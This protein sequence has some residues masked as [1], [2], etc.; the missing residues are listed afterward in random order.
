MKKKL[1]ALLGAVASLA[2]FAGCGEKECTHTYD[3][4]CDTTCNDCGE[5]RTPEA[6]VYDNACDTDCN[7]CGDV[8]TIEHTYDNA[9]DASCNVC[10]D[11]RTPAAHVYDNDCD[12][13]CNVCD[14]TRTASDHV[15]DNACDASC[16]VC[17]DE[18]TPADHVYDNACDASCNVCDD[19]REI[20]HDFA[21]QKGFRPAMFF[22]GGGQFAIAATVDGA[23]KA[24][25]ALGADKNYGYMPA[26]DV[27][28]A[29]GG[30]FTTGADVVYTFTQ[31]GMAD[32]TIQAPDGRYVYMTGTFNSFNLSVDEPTEGHIWTVDTSTGAAK[33]INKTTNKW[34]QYDSNY[35]TYGAYD[36]DK[37]TLPSLYNYIGAS[38]ITDE[39]HHWTV[40]SVCET[41]SDKVA[42]SGGTA[43]CTAQAVCDDCGTSYGDLGGHTFEYEYWMNTDDE[44]WIECDNCN[45][46][47]EGTVGSHSYTLIDSTHAKYDYAACVC[48]KKDESTAFVKKVD[49]LNQTLYLGEQDFIDDL[50]AAAISIAGIDEYV[51]ISSIKV[52]E[53]DLGTDPAALVYPSELKA[54]KTM[55]GKQNIVVTV[56]DAAGL[57][58][59]ILVPV[60][61]ITMYITDVE[62]FESIQPTAENPAIYGYYVLTADITDNSLAGKPY[63]TWNAEEGFF[64]TFDGNGHTIAAAANG[65]SGIFGILRNATIKN[66]TIKD[67]W[68]SNYNGA[69]LI[70]KASF[71]STFNNIEVKLVAGSGNPNVGMTG[72]MTSGWLFSAEFSGN[73]VENFHVDLGTATVGN[74]FGC[75][76]FGNTFEDVTVVGNYTQIG[77]MP[78][79][80][81]EDGNEISAEA[82]ISLEDVEAPISWVEKVEF[83]EVQVIDLSDPNS[84]IDLGDYADAV[85]VS[86]VTAEGYEFNGLSAE[87]ASAVLKNTPSAHG[88]TTI[89]VTVDVEWFGLHE[90]SIPAKIVTRTIK[91]MQEL[92]TYTKSPNNA[93]AV[94]DGYYMLANDVAYN[95]VY[96]ANGNVVS[97]GTEGAVAYA[98]QVANWGWSDGKGFI[99][100]LDGN[101]HTITINASSLNMGLFG[102]VQAGAVIKNVKIVDIW[103]SPSPILGRNAYGATLED[104]EIT[105]S[106]GSDGATGM[107]D[108]APLFGNTVQNITMKNVKITSAKAIGS[109]FYTASGGS[110]TNVT[111]TAPTVA[112]YSGTVT[113][114]PA[115]ITVTQTAAQE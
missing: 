71:S 27:A 97:A 48:G 7:V 68:A 17:G 55:H 56:V 87:Y 43:S 11:E 104:V 53:Y 52:G 77:W 31:V 37:G 60:T 67:N 1:L 91:T 94:I 51:S 115:G 32:Y 113:E 88:E 30:M 29:A 24:F 112:A 59:E 73:T 64:A 98:P 8:R 70:G 95:E 85:L 102:L 82:S 41:P 38:Y 103:N 18:R 21:A 54:D 83:T 61:M 114:F 72:T 107:A 105:I 92:D 106:N 28:F 81:D 57:S 49:I 100:T 19:T 36:S 9:C 101:G 63:C 99:G 13:S 20:T 35:G 5:E 84:K 3:N 96:D 14:E 39:T 22:M 65:G 79:V 34:I 25:A 76:F 89:I 46:K 109:L 16:N 6:H 110:Y 15:Y 75:K 23:G 111:V 80:T 12:A 44:H 42:H 74:I 108:K 47:K 69:Y 86:I 58:H 2:L 50:P 45:A 90:I 62:D 4:A 33:I 40:C 26:A 78:A 66:L 93:T 10:G